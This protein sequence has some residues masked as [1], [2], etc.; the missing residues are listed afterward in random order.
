[1]PRNKREQTAYFE[2][3][4]IDCYVVGLKFILLLQEGGTGN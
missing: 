4:Y 1:M 3:T 2:K